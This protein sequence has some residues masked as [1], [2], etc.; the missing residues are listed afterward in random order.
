[1]RFIDWFDF[2]LIESASLHIY[3]TCCRPRRLRRRRLFDVDVN[4]T[5]THIRD[6]DKD[7]QLT[8]IIFFILSI[9]TSFRFN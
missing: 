1:M 9:Q 2:S 3:V 4:S 6:R 5:E 8:I 7:R